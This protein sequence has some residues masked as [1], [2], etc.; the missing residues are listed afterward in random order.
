M[1]KLNYEGNL[2]NR[3]FQYA[4]ARILADT[5][6]YELVAGPIKGFPRTYDT[7][8][9]DSYQTPPII[10]RG[11]KPNIDFLDTPDL[12]Q[13][14]EVNGYF[15]RYEYY[16]KHTSQ[17]REWFAMDETLDN[18]KI[19]N[20]DL[21][22]GIRR[23]DYI[24][25]HGLP[26]SYYENAIRSVGHKKLFI[27]TDSP[28]DP[29]VRYLAKKYRG[30]IRQPGAI[31]NLAFIK[32]FKKI[33]ISNSTFLWWGAFLSDADEIIFP[34]PAN[35]FWSEAD[36]LSKNIALEVDSPHYKYVPCEPYK[37]EFLGEIVQNIGD[38]MSKTIRKAVRPLLPWKKSH[39][40]PVG[41]KFSEE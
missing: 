39:P 11:Q 10:L 16:S 30:E 13:T 37:S 41:I 24:P 3:L 34:R 2:G 32:K 15:Q 7:V 27:C 38:G 6:R 35:G 12:K 9:G 40:T 25:R 29:F 14:I 31:D 1:I 28:A 19:S 36:P 33:V 18:V 5:L 22:V 20:D 4:F 17:I 26:L 21:V 8:T 23:G